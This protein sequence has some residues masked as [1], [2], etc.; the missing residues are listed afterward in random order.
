MFYHIYADDI[1]LYSFLSTSTPENSQLIACASSIKYWLLSNNLLLN[2]SKTALLN[3]PTNSSSFHFFISTRFLFHL[4]TQSSIFLLFL[5]LIYLFLAI[6]LTFLKQ[7]IIIYLE[8][9]VSVNILLV[10]YVLSLLIHL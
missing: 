4:P 2:T 10:P 5:T 9:D 1:Q 7:I 3:I 8:S 6:L